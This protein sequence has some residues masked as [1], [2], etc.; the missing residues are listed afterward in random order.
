MDFSSGADRFPATRHSAVQA[1]RSDDAETRRRALDAIIEGYWRPVYKYLRL[2]WNKGPEAAEDLTQGFFLRVIEKEFLAGFDPA[3]ARFRTFV[4]VC[5][6]RYVTQE[7]RDASR[8]KRGG[9]SDPLSLDYDDVEGQIASDHVATIGDPQAFFDREWVR[10][11][12][13]TAVDDLRLLCESGNKMIA[14]QLFQKYDLEQ[15]DR[16]E[17]VTYAALAEEYGISTETVTNHLAWARRVFRAAVL[18]RIRSMTAS[19]DEF[20]LEV[21]TVLGVDAP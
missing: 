15:L 18:E 9:G 14:F 13:S 3:K 6:D 12:L 19:D 2:R 16:D 4:R 20:R 10:D 7:D 1:L 17:H 21:R 8:L 5:L 11:L